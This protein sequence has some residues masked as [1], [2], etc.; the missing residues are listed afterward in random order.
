MTAVIE[1]DANDSTPC[2]TYRIMGYYARI[3]NRQGSEYLTVQIFPIV[4]LNDILY[5]KITNDGLN[6][7]RT[8]SY[9]YG[10]DENRLNLS[11]ERE[12]LFPAC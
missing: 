9:C 7:K 8:S 2:T 3:T 4:S 12:K 11:L 5:T 1:F 6:Y 10:F